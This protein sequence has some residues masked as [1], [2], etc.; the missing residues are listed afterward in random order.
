MANGSRAVIEV[1]LR[2]ANIQN[3]L[4]KFE[5]QL[6]NA[7]KDTKIS[8]EV[9]DAKVKDLMNLIQELRNDIDSI[10]HEKVNTGTFNGWSSKTK[11][12]IKE[13][14]D[15]VSDL[16]TTVQSLLG[17]M[18]KSGDTALLN[19]LKS[20]SDASD[21]LNKSLQGTASSLGQLNK[22]MNSSSGKNTFKIDT[23][24]QLNKIKEAKQEINR[25]MS[26][27]EEDINADLT[28]EN[29]ALGT[30]K[31]EKFIEKIKSGK[32]S[33][34][35]VKDF[36][37][38]II[39]QYDKLSTKVANFDPVKENTEGLED[40]VQKLSELSISLQK[41]QLAIP[42]KMAGQ[43]DITQY[44]DKIYDFEDAFQKA[45]SDINK[46]I[47]A[48][49]ADAQES[50]NKIGTTKPKATNIKPSKDT[51]V[52][53]DNG[54]GTGRVQAT[55]PAHIA[56]GAKGQLL[57]ELSS[58]VELLT[59]D[60]KR[61]P[62]EIPVEFTTGY[63][64]RDNK[65]LIKELTRYVKG[66][67]DQ[68][69]DA[70][71]KG[72]DNVISKLEK[73]FNTDIPINFR[74]NIKDVEK[75]VQ[76]GLKAID[77]TL[78]ANKDQMKI[79]PG[80]ELSDEAKNNL[81]EQLNK[82]SKSFQVVLDDVE[83]T[84]DF[85]N[86]VEE[87]IADAG[88]DGAKQAADAVEEVLDHPAKG[89]RWDTEAQG[90][91]KIKEAAQDAGDAIKKATQIQ[92]EINHIHFDIDDETLASL[93]NTFKKL[94]TMADRISKSLLGTDKVDAYT[95]ALVGGLTEVAQKIDSY[96]GSGHQLVDL[97]SSADKMKADFVDVI[98][99]IEAKVVEFTNKFPELFSM[100]TGAAN[101]TDNAKITETTEKA[102]ES[103]KDVS[104]NADKASSSV[105]ELSK[106]QNLDNFLAAIKQV[107]GAFDELENS[108]KNVASS[109][110]KME[111]INNWKKA[112]INAIT[113]IAMK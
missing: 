68:M 86:K 31:A 73:R 29:S 66:S 69:S 40:D 62:V 79:Y 91:V 103:L 18:S 84:S 64:Q 56:E 43:L 23:V 38:D 36:V 112:F 28:D 45:L 8:P 70:E 97:S 39:N 37:D 7:S 94:Q 13:L 22:V 50:L 109:L 85:G 75:S 67:Y 81:Q 46:K 82:I 19:V 32:T 61:H 59:V 15:R 26:D 77:D 87:K 25:I 80:V 88:K 96:F 78:K 44:T 47:D 58:I 93:T 48:T 53:E 49:V 99:A 71:R 1:G 89:Y 9:D 30:D 95:K 41:I 113:E 108:A 21:T 76:R 101:T 51:A 52:I 83:L 12:D 104:E 100:A 27:Y 60:M 92:P 63:A 16:E 110:F 98:D 65:R 33:L 42:D 14:Q 2:F 55:V 72:L 74:T 105:G 4:N 90:F 6:Q 3:E 24:D 35:E 57:K 102:S 111:E 10:S 54:R 106:N 11:T 34:K 17:A 5:K 107:G 20:M